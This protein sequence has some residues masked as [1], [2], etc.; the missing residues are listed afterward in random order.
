VGALLEFGFG[1]A[2]GVTLLFGELYD[3][4][5][6]ANQIQPPHLSPRFWLH[7]MPALLI[8]AGVLL[9]LAT[10]FLKIPADAVTLEP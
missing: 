1:L 9:D 5:L 10:R 4:T 2:F 3:Q 7:L 6:K 8:M